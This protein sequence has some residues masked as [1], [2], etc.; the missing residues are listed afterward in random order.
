MALQTWF[1]WVSILI[2]LSN[3]V[4]K[5]LTLTKGNSIPE[6]AWG[7]SIL[8][9]GKCYKLNLEIFFVYTGNEVKKVDIRAWKSCRILND[10]TSCFNSLNLHKWRLSMKKRDW[11]KLFFLVACCKFLIF[12]RTKVQKCQCRTVRWEIFARKYMGFN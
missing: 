4:P 1:I 8:F 3:I 2:E 11:G 9:K 7:W 10:N 12:S 5:F 6:F